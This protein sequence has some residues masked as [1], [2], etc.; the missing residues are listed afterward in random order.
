MSLVERRLYVACCDQTAFLSVKYIWV[1]LGV[2]LGLGLR[3]RMRT[4]V[5]T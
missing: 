3:M 2:G 5:L 4:R 1:G